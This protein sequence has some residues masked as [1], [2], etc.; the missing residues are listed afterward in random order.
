MPNRRKFPT[1]FNTFNRNKRNFGYKIIKSLPLEEGIEYVLSLPRKTNFS[2]KHIMAELASINPICVCCGIEATKFCL[3]Q[4]KDS[5]LHWD[6]YSED[7]VALSLDH[8][9]PKSK[10]GKNNL[11]NS[12]IMCTEC[13]SLKANKPERIIG[14]KMVLD[15]CEDITLTIRHIPFLRIGYYQQMKQELLCATQDFF[16]EESLWDEDTGWNYIYYF[17]DKTELFSH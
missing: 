15:A 3:G 16:T 17:K 6:L 9:Q 5:G 13:N 4:S 11:G 10:G 8:I 1:V 7:D 12:Q 2:R 14:Y